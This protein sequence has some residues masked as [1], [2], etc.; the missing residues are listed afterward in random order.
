M[1]ASSSGKVF[2]TTYCFFSPT[3][4]ARGKAINLYRVL[5]LV[6]LL[7]GVG[8]L[9]CGGLGTQ[10]NDSGSFGPPYFIGGFLVGFMV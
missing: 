1:D 4:E 5:A 10:Y 8:L 9:A 2:F 6:Q 7:L 3:D